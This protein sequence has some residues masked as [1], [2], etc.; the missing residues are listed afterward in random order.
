[1][2]IPT[3]AI[4]D[5]TRGLPRQRVPLR[6][7]CL[8]TGLSCANFRYL[9]TNIQE[10]GEAYLTAY[11]HRSGEAPR[12]VR[13]D[14]YRTLL[15]GASNEPPSP[16]ALATLPADHFVWSDELA[17]AFSSFIDDC[18]GR[19]QATAD[20]MGLEWHPALL[21]MD[22]L[23]AECEAIDEPRQHAENVEPGTAPRPRGATPTSASPIDR[24]VAMS[25]T[26][27]APATVFI[28]YSHK[29]R[30]W[31]ERLQVNL[32]PLIREGRID[33]WDD[34]RIRPGDQ[35]RQEIERA[36]DAAGIAVMLVSAD[37][38]ASA[39]IQDR[40]I[41][42]L[43]QAAEQRGTRILPVILGHCLFSDSPLG[44]F[45]AF[46]SPD[47]PL[48]GF[49]EPEQERVL[50]DLALALRDNLSAGAPARGSVSTVPQSRAEPYQGGEANG[51]DGGTPGPSGD[52]PATALPSMQQSLGTWVFGGL[53]L[54]FV[55]GVFTFA[56]PELPDYKQRILALCAA[57][58][59]GLFGWFLSGEIGLHI[60][61]L[62][63]RFGDIMIRRL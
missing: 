47:N 11:E 10:W 4:T 26:H 25:T 7:A 15:H 42:A 24:P 32:K 54:V 8:V 51:L 62:K 31:L 34:T 58:L 33:L 49:T 1:V 23:I 50:H 6:Y 48:A 56:P 35:W 19:K 20:G 27:P 40:E 37:F 13:P 59:A 57:L 63:S 55:I 53:L 22:A 30:R 44:R 14:F 45:Q 18:P 46:N 17:G 12:A 21:G 16:D 9:L 38:L 3:L 28:S 61:A 5:E 36:L 43:L 39:F 52:P 2:P 41:P 29:D 60:H